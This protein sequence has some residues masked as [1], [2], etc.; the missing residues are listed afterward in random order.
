M[1]YRSRANKRPK[2]NVCLSSRPLA[3]LGPLKRQLF[4]TC[5]CHI[6]PTSSSPT[7]DKW[8]LASATAASY[9]LSSPI[10]GQVS[11]GLLSA[12][13]ALI[14]LGKM[15]VKGKRRVPCTVR[16]VPCRA[17]C[18]A[19]C[20]VAGLSFSVYRPPLNFSRLIYLPAV[21]FS[22]GQNRER[23]ES[24]Q[25]VL[26]FLPYNGLPALLLPGHKS[27]HPLQ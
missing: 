23:V 7:S 15:C 20:R 21:W 27:S 17:P 9:R 6:P 25:C 24:S 10:F 11:L 2:V 19:P 1:R 5:H 8:Q 13:S 18:R 3:S 14:T 4:R 16:R 12:A 26:W 22:L